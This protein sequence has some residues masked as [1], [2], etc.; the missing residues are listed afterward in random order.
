MYQNKF[1]SKLGFVLAASGSAVGVGNIW[2]FPT[3]AASQGGGAFLL[4][5]L[6]LTFLLGYPMLIAELAVGRFG[7]SNPVDALKKMT[8]QGI[9]RYV[10]T[11]LGTT[12]VVTVT[13]IFS[14]YAIV[15]G[16]FLS[17]SIEPFLRLSGLTKVANWTISLTDSSQLIF[18]F[19]FIGLTAWVVNQGVQNGIERWSSKLMPVLFILLIVLAG[20]MQTFP[21]ASIGL[22][23]Y[24]IPRV[25]RLLQP[26]VLLSAL[27]QT[28]FSL[29]L[30]AGVMLVYGAYLD[31]KASIPSVAAQVAAIDALV[32]FLAG[33]LILPAM[34]VAQDLGET[35]FAADGSLLSADTLVLQVLPALFA[36]MGAMQYVVGPFFFLLMLVAAITSAMSMLEVSV[37]LMSEK[38]QLTRCQCVCIL[39][40]IIAILSATIILNME[41][42]FGLVITITTVYAQPLVSLGVTIYAGWLWKRHAKLKELSNHDTQFEQSLFWRWWSPYVR[43]VCP[44]LVVMVFYHINQ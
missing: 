4:V 19:I 7:Q 27:G 35:I 29:S 40:S 12:A 20:Y 28:F 22:R 39:A 8:P 9:G 26:G 17:W 1:S 14:F 24:L 16:W 42:L 32:A 34:Y 37:S 36:N 10:A 30:G 38:T 33:L 11:G 15:S 2:G 31:R 5:Y 21:G 43:F 13:L 44:V 6:V 41:V 3:Q 23:E 18:T 25:D